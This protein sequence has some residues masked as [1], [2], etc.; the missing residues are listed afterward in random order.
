MTAILYG[1][2]DG[3]WIAFASNR[4][5][6][7]TREFA[8]YLLNPKDKSVIQLTDII[9]DTLQARPAWSSDGKK[10]V[11]NRDYPDGRAE[12]HILELDE[13]LLSKR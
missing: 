2:Q 10:I 1:H 7:T 11:F 8:L 12:I 6:A 4:D 9:K 5:G 13:K 3:K